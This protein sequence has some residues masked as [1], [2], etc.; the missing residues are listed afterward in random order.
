[1]CIGYGITFHGAGLWNFGNEIAR[2]VVIFGV[3]NSSWF[4]TDNRKK[5]FL[6][7]GE[8]DT[9]GINGSL[10]GTEKKFGINFS[11]AKIKFCLSLHYNGDNS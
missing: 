2:N 5:Y 3:D 7:L 11:K 4:H 9:I 1:M 8:G 6:V 10:S